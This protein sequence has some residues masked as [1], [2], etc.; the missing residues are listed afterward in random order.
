MNNTE[1]IVN[2]EVKN[3]VQNPYEHFMFVKFEK[4]V[5]QAETVHCPWQFNTFLH[6]LNKCINDKSMDKIYLGMQA[7]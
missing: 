7:V 4:L 5:E 2:I 3:Q 1:Q 6:E